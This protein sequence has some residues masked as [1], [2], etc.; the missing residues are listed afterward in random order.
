M[1]WN[2]KRHRFG[3]AVALMRIERLQSRL[4]H[5]LRLGATV[6]DD[7]VLSLVHFAG[8]LASIQPLSW[9]LMTK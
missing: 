9:R 6:S 5:D 2:L 4:Q 7:R 1:T 8:L 3:M